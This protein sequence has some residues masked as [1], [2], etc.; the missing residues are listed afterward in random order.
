MSVNM[1]VLLDRLLSEIPMRR[2]QHASVA[3]E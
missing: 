3:L 1:I 2:A